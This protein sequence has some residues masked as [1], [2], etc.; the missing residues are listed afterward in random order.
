[1]QEFPYRPAEARGARMHRRLDLV[2]AAALPLATQFSRWTGIG[3]TEAQ[4]AG[5][6]GGPT[7]PAAGA[8]AI[9]GPIFALLLGYAA[10]RNAAPRAVRTPMTRC[11]AWLATLS[12]AASTLWSLNAQLRG[13][14]WSSVG[15][16]S[17][18]AA[19][20]TGAVAAFEQG[21]R[22][23]GRGGAAA[24][25]IAPLAGWLTVAGFANLETTLNETQGRPEPEAQTHRAVRILAGATVAAVAGAALTRG[26]ALYALAAAWGLGGVAA[27]NRETPAV[28]GAA[29]L[30]LGALAFAAAAVRR[31]P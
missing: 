27:R 1:M 11:G 31:R 21:A 13:L 23:T 25:L 2:L 17:A 4:R 7:T 12:L 19:T 22:R 20:A 24:N 14:G 5:K 28:R 30:G 10:R 9:W 18:G 16:I 6:T 8:F 15:L 29:V 3:M 26:N